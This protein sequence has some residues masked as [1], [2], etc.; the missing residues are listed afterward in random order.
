MIGLAPPE[1]DPAAPTT[2]TTLPVAADATVRG[3]VRELLRRHR[4]AF[5]LLVGV[6]AVAVVASM[7]YLPARIGGGR[8]GH[9]RA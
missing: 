5:A 6:N 1:Y 7:A 9:G 4:R 2:A 8:A 3:Y